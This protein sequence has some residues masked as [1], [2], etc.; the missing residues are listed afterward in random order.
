MPKPILTAYFNRGNTKIALRQHDAA[1]AD[2]DEAIRLK[3]DL[4]E[5]YTSRGT[6]K[7]K[8]DHNEAAIADYDEAIRLKPDLAEAYFNRGN[9]KGKLGRIDEARQDF[10]KA[11][12]LARK[13]GDDSLVALAEQVLLKL[14]SQESD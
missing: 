11:R 14:D 9:T 10:E 6:A 7:N 3:P 5:A 12:D 8:L 13:A 4:A 2:Y 1:I